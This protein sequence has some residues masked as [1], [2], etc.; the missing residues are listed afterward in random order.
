MLYSYMPGMADFEFKLKLE[1][2]T[3]HN[4][5]GPGSREDS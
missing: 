2:G 1:M 3:E 5:R 4:H